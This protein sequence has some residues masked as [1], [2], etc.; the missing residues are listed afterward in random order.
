[1]FVFDTPAPISATVDIIFGDVRF[2]AGDRAD[3]AVAVRPIDPSR[4][5]D[6]EAA[7]QVAVKFADGRLRVAHPKL[8]TAFAKK[9]GSVAILVELP[10][11]SDVRGETAQGEF[12]VQGRVGSCRLKTAIGDIR[13]AQAADA[14]LKTTGGKVVLDRATGR[15]DVSGFGDIRIGRVEGDASVENIGGDI[16]VEAAYAAVEA[17]TVNG[18]I[19]IGE[20]GAGPVD[21]YAAIGGIEVGVPEGAAVRLEANATTGRVR[22]RLEALDRPERL[23]KVRARCN[24]GDIVVRRAGGRDA[25]PRR[26]RL[27]A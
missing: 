8:R 12:T 20:A 16:A 1:M 19:R 11:G 6:V 24:G 10:A 9:Y 27:P 22:D 17:R 26:T 2:V 3:T 21:L 13:V 5:L 25:E 14:R 15:A 4:V 7:E 18:D 23:I